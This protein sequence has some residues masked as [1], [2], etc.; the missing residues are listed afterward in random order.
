MGKQPRVVID[1]TGNAT[2][3]AAALGLAADRGTVVLMGD[4]GSPTRQTLTADVVLRGLNIVGAHDGHNTNEWNV[5][6]ISQLFFNLV[7]SGRFPMTGLTSHVFA[8]EDATEAYITANRD[9]ASTMGLI[10]DWT[11]ELGSKK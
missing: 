6:T 2:V 5:A 9:R 4:T 11:G 10:F 1:S 7:A 8:V 3:F